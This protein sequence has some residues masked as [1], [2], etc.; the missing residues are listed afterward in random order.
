M[1]SSRFSQGTPLRTVVLSIVISLSALLAIAWPVD[2]VTMVSDPKGFRN[3]PWGA[4]LVNQQDLTLARAGPHINEYQ[5]KNGPSQ[6][7][8]TEVDSIL[9]STVNEQFARVTIRYRGEKT[10][11]EVLTYLERNFGV[12]ERAPGR[13]VRG[14]N[15]QFNWQ[16]TDTEINLTYDAHGE[17]GFIFFNSRSLA[18]RFNDYM[19]DSAD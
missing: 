18:P 2:A 1:Q 5:L 4:P 9:F 6:F 19:A 10:H 16:G 17:R 15:Q 12:Q 13:T 11:K 3:I 7:A 14:L 8:E